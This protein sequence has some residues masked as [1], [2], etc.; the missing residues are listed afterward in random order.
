MWFVA[1]LELEMADFEWEMIVAIARFRLHYYSE[2]LSQAHWVMAHF[3]M[4]ESELIAQES[5]QMKLEDY[6]WE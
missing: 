6:C 2:I 3:A 1:A 4:S 5:V